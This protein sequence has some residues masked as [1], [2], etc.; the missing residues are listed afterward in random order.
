MKEARDKIK[1]EIDRIEKIF[2]FCTAYCL[3]P[4]YYLS[5]YH[6]DALGSPRKMTDENGS[7]AWSATYYSFGEMTA[8]GSNTHGF[9]PLE[10]F[11]LMCRGKDFVFIPRF[12]T[13]QAG[14]EFDSE[15]G[16]NYFCQR[17]YDP[18]IGRF[19]TRDLIQIPGVNPY[20]Y[21]YNC[22]LRY[23]DPTGLYSE[24]DWYAVLTGV[25]FGT[26]A[27]KWNIGIGIGVGIGVGLE[28]GRYWDWNMSPAGPS[29]DWSLQT[30]AEYMLGGDPPQEA[31]TVDTQN[32]LTW[33]TTETWN[34]LKELDRAL[35]ENLRALR[36]KLMQL[37]RDFWENLNKK[38]H[39]R[40][41]SRRRR[42]NKFP[43]EEPLFEEGGGGGGPF[44][45]HYPWPGDDEDPG[46]IT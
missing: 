30:S 39:R 45:P 41:T 37:E 24:R 11:S 43:I 25:Y 4:T 10:I 32:P 16:L 6:C 3:L 33:T 36:D 19:M 1:D 14:K 35:S 38:K 34:K 13:G 40:R 28:A 18:E 5:K 22:P 23:R 15:M 12:L 27:A 2:D 44:A 20:M 17:Y 42:Y 8:G 29:L 31:P 46:P 21:C 9:T 7:V 26:C